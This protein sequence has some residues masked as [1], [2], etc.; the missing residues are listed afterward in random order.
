MQHVVLSLEVS[1]EEEGMSMAP[2]HDWG[3]IRIRPTE[4][5]AS[6]SYVLVGRDWKVG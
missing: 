2:G 5:R 4:G 3:W 1:W 6:V